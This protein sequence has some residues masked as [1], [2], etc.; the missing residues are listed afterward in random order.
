MAKIS[1]SV[2]ANGKNRVEDVKTVQAILNRVPP[3]EGGPATPL[4][5]D[6]L[7]YQK[8]TAAIERFQKIGCGF[9]W[10]DRI[11]EPDHKTWIALNRYDPAEPPAPPVPAEPPEPPKCSSHGVLLHSTLAPGASSSSAFVG[12]YLPVKLDAWQRSVARG[13]FGDSLD[14]DSI[15]VVYRTPPGGKGFCSVG[16]M[17]GQNTLMLSSSAKELLIHE[18]THV[19]QSQHHATA[20]KFMWNSAMSQNLANSNGE[21]P[22]WYVVG[23]PFGKYAAEQ[24][25]DMVENGEGYIVDHVRSR[26]VRFHDPMNIESLATPRTQARKPPAKH[27]PAKY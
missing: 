27:A 14:L 23:D 21:S 9:K 13:V 18:L 11:I 20:G 25:A 17:P 24:I 4:K 8:T 19:W 5:V 15:F 12:K 3:A 7:C 10:P 6:G 26:A 16:P 2:G 1:G 22:Y